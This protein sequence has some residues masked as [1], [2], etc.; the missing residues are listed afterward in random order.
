MEHTPQRQSNG[1][2]KED[3]NYNSETSKYRHLTARY[4]CRADSEVFECIGQVKI[5]PNPGCGI[6]IAS[7]GDPVVP[8]AFNYEL[9]EVEFSSYNSGH[10]PLGPVQ[11]SGRAEHL[12]KINNDCLDFVYCSHLLE[13]FVDWEPVLREWIRVLKPNGHLIVL[14]PD[15]DLWAQAMKRGQPPNCFHRHEGKPGELSSYAERLG[16]IV[17]QDRLTNCFEGDYTILFVARKKA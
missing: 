5:C 13:D 11:L 4:C 3:M 6:D 2:K 12:D 15:G 8:W 9:P 17:I 1:F 14:I 10:K 16:L 7:Q